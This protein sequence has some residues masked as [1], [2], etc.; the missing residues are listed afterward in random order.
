[1]VLM[2]AVKLVVMMDAKMAVKMVLMKAVLLAYLMA[3]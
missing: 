3:V 1:M 2:K